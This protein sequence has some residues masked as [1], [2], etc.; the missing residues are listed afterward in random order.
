MK[1]HI[2]VT[3]LNSINFNCRNIFTVILSLTFISSLYAML[4]R[5]VLCILY[6]VDHIERDLAS[7]M[8]IVIV[9]RYPSSRDSLN[10]KRGEIVV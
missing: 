5:N 7:C 4:V 2:Y 1:L 10:L 6:I 9:I 3:E 8:F